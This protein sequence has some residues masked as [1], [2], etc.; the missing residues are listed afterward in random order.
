[1]ETRVAV[2]AR[3]LQRPGIG[4]FVV[5]DALLT[6]L[7][8]AGYRLVLVTDENEHGAALR[9]R[10]PSAEVAVLKRTTWLVWEQIQLP[11]FLFRS[12]LVVMD[13]IPV[14]LARPYMTKRPVWAVQYLISTGLGLLAATR[15]VTISD[16]T[17][18]DVRRVSR[19]HSRIIH[20]PIPA[21]RAERAISDAPLSGEYVVYSGGF[22]TRKNFA[23]VMD[24]FG[25]YKSQHPDS[26]M[27]L[28]VL[29]DR[30]DLVEPMVAERGWQD[31]VIVTGFVS[32]DDKYRYFQG[33]TAVLYPS[34][35]EGFGLVVVEAFAAGVPVICGTG[36]ALRD[37]AADAGLLVDPLSPEGIARLIDQAKDPVERERVRMAGYRQLEVL[38]A[39]STGYAEVVANVVHAP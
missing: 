18:R 16:S 28:V 13:L 21:V 9:E 35:F 24:A 4:Y 36:G 6:E 17:A 12:R 34:S 3:A 32:E 25:I 33:A 23:M 11:A 31:D 15:V 29:G 5:V 20:P 8:D 30:V 10:Y 37:V 14:R 38:R 22:D 2:D 27:K 19:R 1:M 26:A 39:Q 7:D